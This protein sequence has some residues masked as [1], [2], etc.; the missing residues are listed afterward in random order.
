M[1]NQGLFKAADL[2]LEIGKLQVKIKDFME[3]LNNFN[4]SFLVIEALKDFDRSNQEVFIK[5]AREFHQ[6]NPEF[7]EAFCNDTNVPEELRS[8]IE[9]L[10][11]EQGKPVSKSEKAEA[12]APSKDEDVNFDPIQ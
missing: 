2:A 1:M 10:L 4:F 12:E 6:E 9:T 11:T 5:K 8:K 7:L 3:D